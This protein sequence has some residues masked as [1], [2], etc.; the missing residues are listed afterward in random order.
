MLAL[1]QEDVNGIC[2][3][4]LEAQIGSSTYQHTEA[5]K[6]NQEV[7]EASFWTSQRF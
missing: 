5:V 2:V 4:T 3:K 6:W 7:V 1:S